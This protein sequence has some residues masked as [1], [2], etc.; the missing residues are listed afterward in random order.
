MPTD[1][2]NPPPVLP[3]ADGEAPVAAVLRRRVFDASTTLANETK[4]DGRS[5]TGRGAK[6]PKPSPRGKKRRQGRRGPVNPRPPV[7]AGEASAEFGHTWWG[8]RW[9]EAIESVSTAY[10]NR[11]PRGMVYARSGHVS[12]LKVSAGKVEAFV[13]GRRPSPYKVTLALRTLTQSQ[14]KKVIEVLGDRAAFTANLL[15]GEM[16]E[17]ITDVFEQCG[18]S[19]FPRRLRE[20]KATCTCPDWANPCKHIA[21]AHY[22]L[23]EALDKDPFL[24]LSLRGRNRDDVLAAL[25]AARS[26]SE[27]E[28]EPLPNSGKDHLGISVGQLDGA[29]FFEA[30]DDLLDYRF[31]IALPEVEQ[32]ILRRLGDPP[33][34]GAK[35]SLESFLGEV[36]LRTARLAEQLGLREVEAKS[37]PKPEP[38]PEEFEDPPPVEEERRA[39]PPGAEIVPS[40]RE[41][42]SEERDEGVEPRAEGPTV[43]VRRRR[44]TAEAPGAK[45]AGGRKK[46]ENPRRE[47]VVEEP[48][49]VEAKPKKERVVV[50][51]KPVKTKIPKLSRRVVPGTSE[52]GNAPTLEDRLEMLLPITETTPD[53]PKIARQI[54]WALKTHGPATARQLARR[55]RMKKTSVMQLLQSLLAVGLVI[56]D[57]QGERARYSAPDS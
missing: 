53:G 6:G 16:P 29:N 5:R 31:H 49:V 4:A 27:I 44:D 37:L 10:A 7:V 15:A 30:Q 1:E 17:R 13:S 34:W 47:V 28:S 54:I 42:A 25:R 24:L 3:K 45:T 55:T 19:L 35:P 14:W 2:K 39:V 38:L 33:G 18:L 21:A 48:P 26:G 52:D 9:I 36:F 50:V 20:L 43:L 23:G 46:A 22:I 11:L 41:P 57:G 51:E 8:K 40:S 56:Q 12:D 32:Q